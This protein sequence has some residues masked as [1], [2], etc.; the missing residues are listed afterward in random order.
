M[1]RIDFPL[2]NPDADAADTNWMKRVYL[3]IGENQRML[4]QCK[5]LA[6]PFALIRRKEDAQHDTPGDHDEDITM[7]G[8]DTEHQK[9]EELEIAEIVKYKLVFSAR[10]EPI[11]KDVEEN[12]EPV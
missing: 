6:K 8:E 4:G 12:E 9:V 7:G 11:T 5:K 1:G 3:Y 2:Y 10:P